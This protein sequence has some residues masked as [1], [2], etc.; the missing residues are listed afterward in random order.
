[1]ADFLLKESVPVWAPWTGAGCVLAVSF[2]ILSSYG[3]HPNYHLRL[4]YV[5]QLAEAQNPRWVWFC[6]GLVVGGVML[7]AFA[8]FFRKLLP[9]P[10]GLR[11]SRLAMI[12]GV[13]MVLVGFFPL[14]NIVPHFA[15]AFVLFASAI[16]AELFAA[17]SLRQA[18]MPMASRVVFGLFVFHI[19][20]ALGG[21]AYSA[22]V[23]RSMGIQSPAQMLL[24]SPAFQ[25]MELWNAGPVINPV[26][27]LEWVFLATTFGLLLA[28]SAHAWRI[29]QNR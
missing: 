4:N 9:N 10:D 16:F 1:M 20:A 15:C 25:Q 28:A 27:N 3:G 13:F 18:R 29:R 26:A 8:W 21:F 12:A 6:G 23:T 11:T 17:R 14:D 24:E 19:L 5:S 22:V 7:T 2:G